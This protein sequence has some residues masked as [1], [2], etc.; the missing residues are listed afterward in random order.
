MLYNGANEQNDHAL[1]SFAPDATTVSLRDSSFLLLNPQSEKAKAYSL[2]A[3]F[4]EKKA[5]A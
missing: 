2:R 1:W 3:A 4:L 5:M